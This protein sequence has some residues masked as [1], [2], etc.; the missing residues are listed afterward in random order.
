MGDG[1]GRDGVSRPRVVLSTGTLYN[2]ALERVFALAAACRYDGVELLV[3]TR[4]DSSDVPYLRD[5][6]ERVGVPVLSVHTP[7]AE[8]VEGWP[9]EPI[10]RVERSVCLAEALGAE[11]VVAHAPLRWQVGH[12]AVSVGG[13]RLRGLLVLPWRSAAGARYARWLVEDLPALQARTPVRVAIEN[14]PAHRACGRPVQLHRFS[15]AE[16]LAV[17]PHVVLDTTHWGTCGVEP[18][19]V[20]REL[21]GRVCHVHLSDYDGREHR[22]PFKGRLGLA[23][24]LAEMGAAGFRGL[25]VIEAEP[26]AV[27]EGDWSPLHIEHSLARAAAETRAALVEPPSHSHSADM[28]SAPLAFGA[29]A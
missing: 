11:A 8:H 26:S 24:L 4:M 10:A 13:W 19:A 23:A 9:Q 25:V 7:F 21:M 5:L 1:S 29:R 28:A 18:L 27:A 14:M 17:F 3:D 12:V 20:Y 15:S 6:S 16:A 2:W 22:L